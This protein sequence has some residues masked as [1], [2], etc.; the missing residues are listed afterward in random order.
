MKYE[1]EFILLDYFYPLVYIIQPDPEKMK[2][3]GPGRRAYYIVL[4]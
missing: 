3:S 4:F 1:I 2:S